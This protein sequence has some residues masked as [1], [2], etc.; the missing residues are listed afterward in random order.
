M[1]S[2]KLTD[3][4]I[5]ANG[6]MVDVSI[7]KESW[8][9]TLTPADFGLK[10]F[11]SNFEPGRRRLLPQSVLQEINFWEGRGRRAADAFAFEYGGESRGRTKLRW[12]PIGKAGLVVAA[13][14]EARENFFK[15]VQ[16]LVDGYDEHKK[17]MEADF[18]DQW[19]ALK[20]AY[21]PADQ[22]EKAYYFTFRTLEMTFPNQMTA[23]QKFELDQADLAILDRERA[24]KLNKEQLEALRQDYERRLQASIR[25]QQE[26]IVTEANQFVVTMTQTLRGKIVDVFA[27]I[28]DKIKGGKTIIQTNLDTI[29]NTIQEIRQ[30]SDVLGG[31]REF[32]AQLQRVQA[33]IDSPRSFKDDQMAIRELDAAMRS[34]VDYVKTT[35]TVAADRAKTYFGRRLNLQG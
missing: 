12:V 34:T 4:E 19:P 5:Y 28:T 1:S 26:R 9:Q 18:P 3:Q 21:L 13:L 15:A 25:E 31:D 2:V 33:I 8:K 29:R 27:Q 23:V 6:V 16:S 20:T 30:R 17:K 24:D 14:H 10:E 7:G 22:I 11:P 35:D 32:I